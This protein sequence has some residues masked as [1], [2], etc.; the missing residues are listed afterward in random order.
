MKSRWPPDCHTFGE[1]V[2]SDN[3]WVGL[4]IKVRRRKTSTAIEFFKR[5]YGDY[6]KPPE[7]RRVFYLN[8]DNPKDFYRKI[9]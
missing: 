3:P 5:V 6:R 4:F 2:D 7:H 9:K 8:I 1:F